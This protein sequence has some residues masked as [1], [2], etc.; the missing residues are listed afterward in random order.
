IVTSDSWRR[1]DL[2]ARSGAIA[3]NCGLPGPFSIRCTHPA[4]V[5]PLGVQDLPFADCRARTLIRPGADNRTYTDTFA[6]LSELCRRWR[7]TEADG[8]V[9]TC[10]FHG[11]KRYASAAA[12]FQIVLLAAGQ[13][14]LVA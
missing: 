1:K 2:A 11:R 10:D 6:R 5:I 13:Q 14:I 3:H 4:D 12:L 8:T 9:Q 7:G